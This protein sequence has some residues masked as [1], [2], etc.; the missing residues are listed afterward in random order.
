MDYILRLCVSLYSGKYYEIPT[1]IFLYIYSAVYYIDD[2]DENDNMTIM[3]TD[4]TILIY[5]VQ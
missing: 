1:T 3:M 2:D 4:T 5:Y